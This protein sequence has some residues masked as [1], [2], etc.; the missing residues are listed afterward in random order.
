MARVVQLNPR[1]FYDAASDARWYIVDK[2]V[3]SIVGTSAAVSL[4]VSELGKS[5]VVQSSGRLDP[6]VDQCLFT[7]NGRTYCVRDDSLFLHVDVREALRPDIQFK[8]KAMIVTGQCHHC[9]SQF[10]MRLPG[11]TGDNPWKWRGVKLT[12]DC[13]TCEKQSEVLL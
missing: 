11:C 3:T 5:G 7:M 6:L 9:G 1:M 2:G 12:V 4:V 10:T 13:E 8:G